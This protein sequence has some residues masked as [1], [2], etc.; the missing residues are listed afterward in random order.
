VV[1]CELKKLKTNLQDRKEK[2]SIP[3]GINLL[4][5]KLEAKGKANPATGREGP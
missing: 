1:V 4:L 2:V 3:K 5:W